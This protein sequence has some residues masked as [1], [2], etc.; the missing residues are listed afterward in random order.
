MKMA[1]VT[2]E[3]QGP[4][5]QGKNID[6]LEVPKKNKETPPDYEERVWR[7]RMHVTGDGHVLI[8]AESFSGCVRTAAKRQQ[9]PIP[10]KRMQNYTK[11]FEAG[12]NA[13]EDL[14]LPVKA[15][16]V[17][18]ERLF[19]PSDG[20]RG[21]DK[22]VYKRFPR[23]ERWG[24]RVRFLIAD[25]AITESVFTQVVVFAGALVGIGRFRPERCGSYGKFFVKEVEWR[26]E[27]G[28]ADF[29]PGTP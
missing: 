14:V 23:V 18:G 7:H 9:I 11:S 24:G 25:D 3:S 16:E 22:R 1:I 20:K 29:A 13:M 8:P 4:Y 15:D 28:L 26:E 5:S 17:K 12:V 2:L 19:V 27:V 10:G 6:P 21:G